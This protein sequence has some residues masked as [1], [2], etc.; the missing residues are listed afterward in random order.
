MTELTRYR[1]TE[2]GI[3]FCH[4]SIHNESQKD[5]KVFLIQFN[6]GQLGTINESEV[7]IDVDL[8]K[9]KTLEDELLAKLSH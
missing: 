4:Y 7:E 9:I 8:K 1:N 2:N 3:E 5:K 6:C